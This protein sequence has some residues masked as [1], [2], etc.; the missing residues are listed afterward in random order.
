LLIVISP[1]FAR[2]RWIS[3]SRSSAGPLERGLGAGEEL[4]APL[5]Q[6]RRRHAKL[7]GQAVERLAAQHAEE[8]LRFRRA[9]NRPGSRGP[10][11]SGPA[12][13]A[14]AFLSLLRLPM[15]TSLAE[16]HAPQ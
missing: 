1:T 11:A 10:A 7:P 12:A 9:E 3:S 15:A 2:S 13:R 14:R 4:L 8:R 16:H 5:R 6:G